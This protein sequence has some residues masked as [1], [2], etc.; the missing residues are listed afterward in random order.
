MDN[1]RGSGR[2]GRGFGIRGSLSGALHRPQSSDQHRGRARGR[3]FSSNNQPITYVI[4]ITKRTF[5]TKKTFSLVEILT[6]SMLLEQQRRHR[7]KK[8]I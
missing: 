1:P 5:G 3:P 2:R 7:G 8:P 4:S 6:M